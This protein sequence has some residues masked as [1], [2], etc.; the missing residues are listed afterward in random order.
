MTNW[1]F[2]ASDPVDVSIDTWASG[3]IVVAAE[4][5]STVTVEVTPSHSRDDVQDLLALIEVTFDDGQLLVRGP[6]AGIFRRRQGLDLTIRVPEGSSCAAKTMSA[7]L[8][9]VGDLS[10]LS[11]KTASGDLTAPVV[12]GDVTVR[13]ASGDLMLEA[14]GGSVTVNT[15]SG[16]FRCRSVD[17]PAQINTASGDVQ[18]GRCG[19]SVAARTASGDVRLG[20]VAAG[21]IELSSASGDLFVGVVPGRGVY[22]DLSSTSGDIH[23][24]L[25]AADGYDDD[26][27]EATI[28]ISCRTL[29]GDIQIRRA[30]GSAVE[31]PELA[32]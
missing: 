1:E 3:A 22:L 29:S 19:G 13:S 14:V 26:A 12:S 25:E 7:D 6:Q 24:E 2:A 8:T 27:A 17:G 28:R 15:A 20:T 5:T 16:D 4:P 23:S 10:A 30:R 9:V 32:H 21:E 31:Q 11:L 18:I